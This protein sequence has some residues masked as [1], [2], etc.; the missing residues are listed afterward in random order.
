MKEEG[1]K[2]CWMCGDRDETLK[3]FNRECEKLSQG[4]QYKKGM[5][6][7]P[8]SIIHL[9]PGALHGFKRTDMSMPVLE[10]EDT[11][12]ILTPKF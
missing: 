3:H 7:W 9:E 8:P 11:E 10:N 6:R 5:A 4:G 1:N 12:I 2:K